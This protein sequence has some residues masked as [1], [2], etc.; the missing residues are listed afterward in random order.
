MSKD[1]YPAAA[2][3]LYEWRGFRFHSPSHIGQ[4]IAQTGGPL[5]D[6]SSHNMKH[7]GLVFGSEGPAEI[8]TW[9]HYFETGTF[10]SH[11]PR[12]T[13]VT[14]HMLI[15]AKSE[16]EWLKRMM[17][18]LKRAIYKAWRA[19]WALLWGSRVW[20]PPSKTNEGDGAMRPLGSDSGN[21]QYDR[22]QRHTSRHLSCNETVKTWMYLVEL[23]RSFSVS[24]FSCTA[25]PLGGLQASLSSAQNLIRATV[26]R[27]EKLCVYF[28]TRGPV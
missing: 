23:F 8:E 20:L 15:R 5:Y 17:P 13:A 1:L 19:K 26:A 12:A 16:D 9:V 27:M 28:S 21:A 14:F 2:R 24:M 22:R 11:F 6:L 25:V 4:F 7:V 18:R 3:V 10:K